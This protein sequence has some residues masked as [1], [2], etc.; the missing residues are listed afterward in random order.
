MWHSW[1][2]CTG[3]DQ[4]CSWWAKLRH[5]A[6]HH[7]RLVALCDDF[8]SRKPFE[9]VEKETP[10]PR[11]TM[12]VFWQYEPI[13]NDIS[14]AVGDVLHC[15]RSALD[16][17]VYGIVE[18][19]VGAPTEQQERACQFP[20]EATPVGFDNF[21]G[22]HGCAQNS[23]AT[24]CVQRC[25]RCSPSTGLS[26][27]SSNSPRSTCPKDTKTLLS[28]IVSGFANLDASNFFPPAAAI[29]RSSMSLSTV[30][31]SGTSAGAASDRY[32]SNILKHRR[33]AAESIRAEFGRLDL[34]VNN[35]GIS[36]TRRG[37]FTM[38]EYANESKA[39]TAS[40]EEIRAVWDVTSSAWSPSTRPC[41][42]CESRRTPASSTCR[43]ESDRSRR[44]RTRTT[45]TTRC[46]DRS[47]R[48][49]RRRSTR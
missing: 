49:P 21:I 48:R 44:M 6:D 27:P 8:R 10:D 26:T 31:P 34:L 9:V 29:C 35:A 24:R 42:C 45:P 39:S 23:T 20:I 22:G 32:L 28:M 18:G 12:F 19:E 46:S 13:P 15:L 37:G 33:L 43:A 47:I 25:A 3:Y 30:W 1:T 7:E 36:N 16:S 14:L 41:C 17:L 38:Q 40:L 5:A 2:T 11:V 4:E